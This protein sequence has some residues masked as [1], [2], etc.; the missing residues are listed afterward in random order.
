MDNKIKLR[1]TDEL[2]IQGIVLD[3]TKPWHQTQDDTDIRYR[4]SRY[5]SC[6]EEIAQSAILLQVQ[7]TLSIVELF[8]VSLKYKKNYSYPQHGDSKKYYSE[9]LIIVGKSRFWNM[10]RQPCSYQF[11]DHPVGTCSLNRTWRAKV[12]SLHAH[13]SR[14]FRGDV[15]LWYHRSMWLIWDNLKLRYSRS[16]RHPDRI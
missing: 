1:V 6:V 14:I 10:T 13:L 15:K 12:A 7:L 9:I 16:L 2:K 11:C 8:G 3:C 4:K 5:V